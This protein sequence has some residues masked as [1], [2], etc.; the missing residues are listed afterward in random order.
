M[1]H[2]FDRARCL[3]LIEGLEKLGKNYLTYWYSDRELT[4]YLILLNDDENWK[5]RSQ[6]LHL[7]ESF[8]RGSI[9]SDKFIDKFY[10][11]R[12]LNLDAANMRKKNIENEIDFE[13]P[14]ESRG[15][16]DVVS[17]IFDSIEFKNIVRN[18]KFLTISVC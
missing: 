6:Y 8:I 10:D 17:A 11:L 13:L 2:K 3:E 7:L 12:Y 9:E 14:R 15:F 1:N 18:F 5:S 4:H 16:S